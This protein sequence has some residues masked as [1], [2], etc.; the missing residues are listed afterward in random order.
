MSKSDISFKQELYRKGIHLISMLIPAGY[1]FVDKGNA[2]LIIIPLTVIAVVIDVMSKSNIVIHHLLYGY[3]G[4]ILRPHERKKFVLNGASWVLISATLCILFF[5]KIVMVTA[6][7][8]LIISDIS[9][10]L[11]GKKYG[12]IPFL[13]KSLIGTSAFIISALIVCTIIGMF[14]NA[15]TTYYIASYIGS[16]VGGI[17][18]AASR[19]LNVDDNLSIPVSVG[20]VLLIASWIFHIN[21]TSSF[22]NIL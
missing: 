6:F 20:L 12:R 8:I 3:F 5:P 18:E 13:D 10:A 4:K 21:N 1:I 15:P 17:V 16:I 9:A 14:T 2:L 7:T 22:L 19:R 11:I